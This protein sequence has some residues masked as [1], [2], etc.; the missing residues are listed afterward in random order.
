MLAAIR[1]FFADL[2]GS[3]ERAFEETDH[4]LAAAALLV[5]II[6]IDGIASDEEKRK[7]RT[8]LKHRYELSDEETDDLI[9][10]AE[11]ADRESVGLYTFTSVLKRKLDAADR[12]KIIGMMWEIVFADGRVDEF[13]DNVVWRVAELLGISSR[14]RVRLKQMAR[15]ISGA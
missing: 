14:D 4:R 8:L 5:H 6:A 2:T 7:L 9:A 15:R 1:E 3:E 12:E 13:E 11:S 10:A